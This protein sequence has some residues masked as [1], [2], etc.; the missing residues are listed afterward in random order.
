[1]KLIISAPTGKPVGSE[2]VTKLEPTDLPVGAF[3]KNGKYVGALKKHENPTFETTS[4]LNSILNTD[5]EL[6]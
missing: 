3:K 2:Y 6:S 1:M 4:F 5:A